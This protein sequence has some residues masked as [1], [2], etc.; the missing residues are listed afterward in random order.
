[1][2]INYNSP[3][4][5]LLYEDWIPVLNRDG[6]ER[7]LGL[8]DLF[9]A[10]PKIDR[11]VAELPTVSLA[12][13]ALAQAI[14]RRA[15]TEHYGPDKYTAIPAVV[16]FWDDWEP[17][18]DL[19]RDYLGRFADRF[20]LRHPS[21]PFYQVADLHTP[22][23]EASGLE[24]LLADVPNGIPFL[25]MRR[26]R[27]LESI[28]WDEAARWLVHVQAF[29]PSGI[30]SGLVGDRRV[31]SGKVY[32]IGPAWAAQ[33]GI[34]SP[35]KG[36]FAHDLILAAVPSGDGYLEYDSA[37]DL[38][39]WERP[40]QTVRPEGIPDS[41][42]ETGTAAEIRDE[43]RLPTGPAD[44]LTWQSRRVRLVETNNVVTG[45]VLT[46]GDPIDP[47]NR[48]TSEP[49]TAWRYS[50]L[51]SKKLDQVVYYP[52]DLPAGSMLWREIETVFPESIKKGVFGRSKEE[53][54]AFRG[55]ASSRWIADL[56]DENLTG[57]EQLVGQVTFEAV[58]MVLGDNR[59]TIAD[60][61]VSRLALPAAAL[62]EDKAAIR[63]DLVAWVEMAEK[64]SRVVAD[65][66]ANLY[67]AAG[68]QEVAGIRD[69]ARASF[70]AA[71]EPYFQ[72]MMTKVSVV[73]AG[74]NDAL[75]Q[76]W[77]TQLRNLAY[78]ERRRLMEQTGPEAVVGRSVGGRFLSAGRAE[79][80]FVSGLTKAL[81]RSSND[82]NE[83]E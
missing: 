27:G 80:F 78:Q 1:M 4:Y 12:I 20:D 17:V 48:Y 73:S 53:V 32:P 46:N 65:L 3:T 40:Q 38:P 19:V 71:T 5:N 70:L 81:G 16:R 56:E 8:I 9:E 57:R 66:A 25:T 41:V 42:W 10:A 22:R 31:Q 75:Y 6:T 24:V 37:K 74:D 50:E 45:V 72:E 47:W 28:E 62:R 67:R 59:S 34:L 61:V 64:V 7:K 39:V 44:I 2:A 49:R 23:G 82:A 29:D 36:N 77:A 60:I 13:E 69:E 55:P 30:R 51:K 83:T 79:A 52:R 26:A 18:S 58:G 33:L 63:S 54:D 76:V 15:T 68:V 43:R 14:Y 21:T 35:R 11:I